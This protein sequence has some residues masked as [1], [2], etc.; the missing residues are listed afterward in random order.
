[1]SGSLAAAA[2]NL[3]PGTDAASALKIQAPLSPEPVDFTKR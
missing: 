1:M 3:Q 2:G